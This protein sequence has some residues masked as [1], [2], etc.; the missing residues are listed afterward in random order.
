[1]FI[2]VEN[3]SNPK[4]TWK[5]IEQKKNYRKRG[6]SS[7][8][9]VCEKWDDEEE[10]QRVNGRSISRKEEIMGRDLRAGDLEQ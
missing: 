7:F 9:A 4:R 2:D 6:G 1:M 10:D 8:C 5:M 3:Y